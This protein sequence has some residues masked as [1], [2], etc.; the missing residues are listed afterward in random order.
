[1]NQQQYHYLLVVL[2]IT[3]LLVLQQQYAKTKTIQSFRKTKEES[4]SSIKSLVEDTIKNLAPFNRAS[5]TLEPSVC[6]DKHRELWGNKHHGGW[7]V[8][9]DPELLYSHKSDCIVY[10][11]GLGNNTTGDS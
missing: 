3:L 9:S 4:S 2:L 1:M 10:S 6:K 11:Y 8:C 5:R 7:Y